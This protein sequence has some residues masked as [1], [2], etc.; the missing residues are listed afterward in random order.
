MPAHACLWTLVSRFVLLPLSNIEEIVARGQQ[1]RRNRIVSGVYAYS[2]LTVQRCNSKSATHNESALILCLTTMLHSE[3][4]EFA[5]SPHRRSRR[6]SAKRWIDV[7]GSS[8]SRNM[9]LSSLFTR[10]VTVPHP[11]TTVTCLFSRQ[12][13]REACSYPAFTTSPHPQPALPSSVWIL[14]FPLNPNSS[15][16]P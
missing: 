3:P 2:S 4:F 9:P 16:L 14:P 6:P 12:S 15:P 13:S 10:V 1:S 8:D 7:I 5:R 11:Q